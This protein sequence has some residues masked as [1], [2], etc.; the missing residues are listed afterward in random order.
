MKILVTGGAGFIGSK[1]VDGYIQGG[2]QVVVVDYLSTGK[3]ENLN[4]EADFYQ[5][6][7]RSKEIESILERERTEILNHHAAQIS[8]PASVADPRQDADIN[9]MGLLNL[10]ESAVKYSVKKF[11]FNDTGSFHSV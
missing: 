6:D 10:L 8:V 7:I 11:I 3:K 4:R 2:H 5:V 9:I 1:V